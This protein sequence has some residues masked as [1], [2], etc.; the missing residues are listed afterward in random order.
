M[1]FQAAHAVGKASGIEHVFQ[2]VALVVSQVVIEEVVGGGYG[3]AGVAAVQI[4][5]HE[6]VY[7]VNPGGPV[8]EGSEAF[9]GFSQVGR[10][11]IYDVGEGVFF[12]AEAG[13]AGEPAVVFPGA[14]SV[15]LFAWRWNGKRLVEHGVQLLAFFGVGFGV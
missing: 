11:L 4:H 7:G 13:G 9:P 10:V 6:F 12:Y 8:H 2:F 1:V 14:V 15:A 5:E 3:C